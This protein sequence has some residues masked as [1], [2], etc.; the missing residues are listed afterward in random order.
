MTEYLAFLEIKVDDMCPGSGQIYSFTERMNK[1]MNEF[2]ILD[3]SHTDISSQRMISWHAW[4]QEVMKLTMY[5]IATGQ[6]CVKKHTCTNDCGHCDSSIYPKLQGP[7]SRIG[8][9]SVKDKTSLS[10]G[11]RQWCLGSCCAC[12]SACGDLL[13][14]WT[15]PQPQGFLPHL[16]SATWF[17]WKTPP[18]HCGVSLGKHAGFLAAAPLPPLRIPSP[19][20]LFII[21]QPCLQH[22]DM[23]KIFLLFSSHCH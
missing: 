5:K 7:A 12:C 11:A 16:S 3:F 14:C 4:W 15:T 2:V 1:W 6:N 10:H 22:K 8:P 17:L 9:A 23:K 20:S 18:Q 19:P 21:G 13:P